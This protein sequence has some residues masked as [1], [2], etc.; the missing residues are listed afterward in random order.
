LTRNRCKILIFLKIE[1]YMN[2]WSQREFRREYGVRPPERR[3]LGGY[4]SN[5][6]INGI[7]GNRAF[8][9][10][11]SKQIKMWVLFGRLLM[12]SPKKSISRASAEIEMGPNLGDASGCIAPT[13]NLAA[14]TRNLGNIKDR[15]SD[16]P[17]KGL[18]WKQ[19]K[20]VN[21]RNHILTFQS[22]EARHR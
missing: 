11:I 15:I 8:L 9:V 7:V 13:T 3:A 22:K 12:L 10:G 1:F 20:Q 19:R 4:A 18:C 2:F 6:M 14:S 17:A 16:Q 21:L 5:L